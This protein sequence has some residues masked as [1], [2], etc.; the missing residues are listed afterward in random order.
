MM[1]R[2]FVQAREEEKERGRAEALRDK[3]MINNTW[4]SQHIYTA[5]S[6]VS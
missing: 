2:E 6:F 5:G 4:R 3:Q 1:K